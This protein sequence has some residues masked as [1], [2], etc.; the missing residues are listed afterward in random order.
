MQYSER[1]LSYFDSTTHAG[2]LEGEGVC[3]GSAH[4][5][6]NGDSIKFYCKIL[7]QNIVELRFLATGTV[8]TIVCGEFL[9]RYLEGKTLDQIEELDAEQ[10][11]NALEL[12]LTKRYSASLAIDALQAMTLN[13]RT[14]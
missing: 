7:S 1:A 5:E 2:K 14:K 4:S 9:S 6:V 8:S 11:L 12:P 10:I 3:S 13:E